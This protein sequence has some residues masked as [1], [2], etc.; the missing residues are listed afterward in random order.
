MKDHQEGPGGYGD[1]TGT[2]AMLR[3]SFLAELEVHNPTLMEYNRK[4]VE[5]RAMFYNLHNNY[6]TNTSGWIEEYAKYEWDVTQR[7]QFPSDVDTWMNDLVIYIRSE[8]A[9]A[10]PTVTDGFAR[11]RAREVA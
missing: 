5:L 8:S 7:G 3:Q 6:T 2:D 4:G 10:D 1:E 11:T 9:S